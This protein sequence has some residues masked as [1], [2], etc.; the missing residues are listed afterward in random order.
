VTYVLFPEDIAG[1]SATK[2]SAI[3]GKARALA[4]LTAADLPIPPWFVVL[5]DAFW[6]SLPDGQRLAANDDAALADVVSRATPTAAVVAATT[7]AFDRLS[8]DG[9]PVAV[10]SSASD[11][12]GSQHSF[13]GQL[14]TFLFVDRDQV[15]ARVAAVWQSGFT[16]RILAYRRQHNLDPVPRP[17][18][19]LVQRM[20]DA[21]IAGVAFSADPVSGRRATA[22]VSAAWGLGTGVVSGECDADTWHVD[23]SGRIVERAIAAKRIAHRRSASNVEGVRA[24]PVDADAAAR[25]ALSDDM[26][27]SVAELARRAEHHFGR[28]QDIE[29]AVE[30]DRLYLLQSRPITSLTALPDPDGSLTIWDNSNIVESY[31]GVTTPLTFSF[32]S[33][34]Y[35]HVYRQFCR[36]MRVPEREIARH[37]QTFRNMLGLIRGRLYYNLLN[38]YRVLA[39]LPG[40]AVNRRFMEQMMGVR[41]PLPDVLVQQFARPRTI[42][43]VVD[44]LRMI[45]SAIGLVGQHFSIDRRVRKFYARLDDALAPPAPP[46]ADRRLDELA[47]HY[48]DL[49]DRLLLH[50]DAPLVNDFFAMVFY[51]VLRK[52]TQSWCGDQEGTLQND[53]ISGQGGLVSAEPAIRLKRLAALAQ[54]DPSFV[55]LLTT[56]SAGRIEAAMNEQTAFAREYRSYLDKFGERSVN[57]LKLETAT[58]HDDPLPLLRAIGGLAHQ[59]SVASTAGPAGTFAVSGDALRKG[60]DEKVTLAL[61]SRPV[62]RVI[63]DWVLRNARARVRDRENLRLERT[64]LFGR[65]RRIFLEMGRR[66]TAI[67]VLPDPRDVFYLEVDELL[68]YVEGRSTSTALRELTA[69]RRRE[70]DEYERGPAPDDRFETRGAVYPGHSFRSQAT[71][72]LADGDE[73]RGIGCCPGVVRGPVRVVTDPRLVDLQRQAVLVAEHTDPGWIMI[74]PSAMGVLVERGSLL[75]HAA[76]VARELGIPAIVSV[77]GVTRWLKDGDWVELDG[78][79]G[80]VRRTAAPAAA[81]ASRAQ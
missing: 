65:V 57:E 5:P 69:L 47:A 17:P 73:R 75:S 63:F 51:G 23:R 71:A 8:P 39:L 54:N 37:N 60:A 81:E 55:T 26:A 7:A 25:P 77:P 48:R 3:G 66:L 43:R 2:P 70:F 52:L 79:T 53:L 27:Q 33:E 4:A 11:E 68:A 74:F 31:S 36:M 76:I 12:D 58:L 41:E 18:A 24:E 44:A 62:R 56:A 64:R 28:P 46:L 1:A 13:A 10:R 19:V 42:D 29:W 49:S 34:I 16:P 45:N 80:I 30:G 6:A 72:P 15:A 61:A 22:V 20:I 14:D 21:T 78:S 9:R 38:W 59:Q 35:E 32:A 50:W 40:F 67:D